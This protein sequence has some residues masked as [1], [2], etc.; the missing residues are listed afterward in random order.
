MDDT[1]LFDGHDGGDLP[2]VSYRFLPVELGTF[3]KL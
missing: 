1:Q 2:G 3:G